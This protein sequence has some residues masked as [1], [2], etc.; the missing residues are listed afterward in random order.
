MEC[1]FETYKIHYDIQRY[2]PQAVEDAL[3]KQL[4]E[5]ET[6]EAIYKED[7]HNHRKYCAVDQPKFICME[8]ISFQYLFVRVVNH[9]TA[10]VQKGNNRTNDCAAN[11]PQENCHNDTVILITISQMAWERVS[12]NFP[13]YSI[14]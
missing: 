13:E 7:H 4:Q 12:S 11:S 5:R 14:T 10:P 3:H 1:A 9:H 6:A 2:N 8:N